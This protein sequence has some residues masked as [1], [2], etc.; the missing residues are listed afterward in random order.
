LAQALTSSLL[1]VRQRVASRSNLRRIL[2]KQFPHR[3]G[4]ALEDM[5]TISITMT[6]QT[7]FKQAQLLPG[8][9]PE[10]IVEHGGT[11]AL[12]EVWPGTESP[13]ANRRATQPSVS[14]R[15]PQPCV[16]QSSTERAFFGL[17]ALSA[18]VGVGQG[19]TLMIEMTPNWPLFNALVAR[20]LG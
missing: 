1:A 12:R 5:K 6:K 9:T 11:G 4:I 10:M 16:D 3:P 13:P 19:I 20:L 8:L 7:T 18:A 2:L 17:L 15:L 14:T